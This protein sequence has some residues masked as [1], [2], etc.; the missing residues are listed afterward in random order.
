MVYSIVFLLL[1]F[2]AFHYDYRKNVFLKKAYYVLVFLVMTSMTALRYRVGGD[3]LLYE[4]YFKHM[5]D[6]GD[7]FYFLRKVNLSFGYQPLYLLFVAV[8]KT[9]NT[10]YYF[11]QAVHAVIFNLIVFRFV[12]KRSVHPFSV[13]SVFF[14]SCIYFYFFFDI[15]REALAICCF[16]LGYRYFEKKNYV[17]YYLFAV[18]GFFFHISA[19]ILLL[20]PLFRLVKLTHK[21]IYI[22]VF[23]GIPLILLKSSIVS[24]LSIFLFTSAM[25][26]KAEVYSEMEFS[27]AGSLFFYAGR[28]LTLLPLMLFYIRQ[29]PEH[30]KHD[31]LLAGFL[32]VSIFSQVMVGFE[33]LLN[34]LFI[35]F[36]I[37]FID[38]VFRLSKSHVRLKKIAVFATL[39]NIIFVINIKIIMDLSVVGRARYNS[40]FFPYTS[41]FE[42]KKNPERERF[43]I[44]LWDR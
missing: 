5:P 38:L 12:F 14:V 20:L 31:W 19:V 33:R 36:F 3:A 28:V 7:Y 39:I 40:I 9:I 44:E 29:K 16:L 11:Y 37:I 21:L 43:M 23:A 32:I 4:D 18:T 27:V 26:D 30:R 25:Q 15:Q 1:L 2:G 24:I 22:L 8:C 42:K 41:V 35:P 13:L 10:D 34:Y 6:L 17:I